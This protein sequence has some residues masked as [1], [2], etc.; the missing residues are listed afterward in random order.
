M[1][2][3]KFLL[4][5]TALSCMLTMSACN[6]KQDGTDTDN[7][8]RETTAS[9]AAENSSETTVIDVFSEL[10]VSF[11]GENGEGKIICEY[12][13]DNEFIKNDVKFKGEEAG[14][15]TNGDTAVVKLDYS[16]YRAENANVFFKEKEK[17]YTVEGLW[18]V[19]L[20][21]DG[22]DFSECNKALAERLLDKE[23]SDSQDNIKMFDVG[24]TFWTAYIDGESE[25]A[26]W[27]II[28]AKYEP[29]QGKFFIPEYSS[30]ISNDYFIFYKATLLCERIED[31][32]GISSES[33]YAVGDTK[34]WNFV[35]CEDTHNVF[36]EK[37]SNIVKA[38]PEAYR[39]TAYGGGSIDVM[40][41]WSV[42]GMGL[43]SETEYHDNFDEFFEKISRLHQGEFYDIEI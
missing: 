34:E 6:K 17:E 39:M 10:K 21:A 27:K 15:Y 30:K 9:K 23:R 3:K 26:S 2:T 18:G 40:S 29:I 12:T 33:Q 42:Y 14:G 16:D 28:S 5:I 31:D 8:S 35:I 11:E 36:V 41:R 32:Y 38:D 20:S 37:N 4:I 43:N 24:N 7:V 19:I 22:Y 1:K 25:H 13:G